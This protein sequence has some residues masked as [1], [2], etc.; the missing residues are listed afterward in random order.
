LRFLPTSETPLQ[1]ERVPGGPLRKK[2][3]LTKG[4]RP[5]LSH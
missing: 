5:D 4:R 1:Y 2:M 3:T